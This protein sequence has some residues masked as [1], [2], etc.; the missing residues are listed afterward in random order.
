VDVAD[1]HQRW[2]GVIAGNRYRSM[3]SSMV[4]VADPCDPDRRPVSFVDA[5]DFRAS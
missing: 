4:M 1:A 2:L 5:D 3:P